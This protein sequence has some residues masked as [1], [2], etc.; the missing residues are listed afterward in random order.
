M[1]EPDTQTW[2][3]KY[4]ALEDNLLNWYPDE[5]KYHEKKPEGVIYCEECRI[6][7]LDSSE[8][9]TN[10]PVPHLNNIFEINS[11]KIKITIAAASHQ[12]LREWMTEIR[13]AKKKKR[14]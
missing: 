6:Y 8:I 4:F 11:G 12:E 13:V 14:G 3:K 7:E 9:P 2:N 10:L 1:T 5:E